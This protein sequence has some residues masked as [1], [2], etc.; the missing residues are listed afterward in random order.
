MKSL[1]FT[2]IK[3]H[4]VMHCTFTGMRQTVPDDLL[5]NGLYIPQE[6]L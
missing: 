1:M 3:C 2:L 4:L 6:N 5:E